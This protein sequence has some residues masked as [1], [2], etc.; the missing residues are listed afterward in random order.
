MTLN[1]IIVSALAQLDRGNDPQ[2]LDVWREKFT[3]FANDA[4]EDLAAALQYR[5]QESLTAAD[6]TLDLT[7]L[8][9]P[10][11]KVVL[12]QDSKGRAIPI[13]QAGQSW[14]LAAPAEGEYLVTYRCKPRALT[15]PSDEPELPAHC[16]GL[17]VTYVAARERM[18]GDAATQRGA[19]IYFELYQAGKAKL[20]PHV[21]DAEAYRIRN[22]W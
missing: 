19:G 13:K 7:Q 9:R 16:H 17:I 11:V 1:D 21:G 20:R 2:T 15:S 6:G 3:R 12:V 10:C 5:R 4:Q 14:T 22:R 8:S 18:S